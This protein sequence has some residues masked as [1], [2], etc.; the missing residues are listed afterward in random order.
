MKPKQR[1]LNLFTRKQ[2]IKDKMGLNSEEDKV[3]TWLAAQRGHR[4]NRSSRATN[5]SSSATKLYVST[6]LS[7]F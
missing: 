7:Y 3:A 6:K 1:Q 5:N 4:R 2:E